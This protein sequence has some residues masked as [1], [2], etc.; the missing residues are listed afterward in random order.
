MAEHDTPCREGVDLDYPIAATT[1]VEMGVMVATDAAGNAV[2]A[3]D[4]ASRRV[5]GVAIKT[6]DNSAGLAGALSCVA[7]AR[8]VFLFENDTVNPVLAAHRGGLCYVEDDH[9]VCASAGSV[10]GVVAGVVVS[11]TSAG[12]EVYID[13]PQSHAESAAV[14]FAVG[15]DLSVVRNSTFGGTV[16]ITG[17]L[18]C[19][20]AADFDGGLT[21][22]AGKAVTGD[23]AMSLV[24]ATGDL[25]IKA[26]DGN[27][28]AT[29]GDKVGAKEL[30]INDSD[31]VKMVSFNSDGLATVKGLHVDG[32]VCNAPHAAVNTGGAPTQVEMA[33][34]FGAASDG[35]I[36]ILDDTAPGV[37][38]LC[39]ATAARAWHQ[40]ALALGA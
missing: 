29:L 32:L 35:A 19:T 30:Q 9:T 22:A 14:D 39:A 26:T 13:G 20:A 38:Y 11:V 25:T 40:V 23:G 15:R 12:V 31:A 24:T 17:K 28:I 2:E 3:T 5:V 36:G 21:L 10:N 4:A 8:R 33:A 1:T 7:R 34:A 27:V 18:T 6:Y 16:A 37:L